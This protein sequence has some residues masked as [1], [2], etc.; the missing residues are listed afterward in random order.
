MTTS[1]N[2]PY[3]IA[4]ELERPQYDTD[5]Y[6]ADAH[7]TDGVIDYPDEDGE[8]M[9]EG[10]IQRDYIHYSTKA[11][12][13]YYRH[14]PDV[15]VSGNLFIYYEE[16]N[17]R[18]SLAPDT[19]V[20]IGIPN[21]D[22]NTYKVWLEGG[23][24]PDFA[25]EI[26]SHSTVQKDN[27][28]KV[29]LYQQLGVQEYIQYDPTAQYLQPVP[30]IGYQ[31]VNGVYKPMLPR[32]LA[33]GTLCLASHVLNLELHL[34]SYGLRFYDPEQQ[35]YLLTQE[36]TEYALEQAEQARLQAEQARL[37]AEQARLQ[38]EQIAQRLAERLRELGVDPDTVV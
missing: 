2:P 24:L 17:P 20:V 36:E 4:D 8:G 22:R 7:D 11:L 30:L 14:R 19:F 31:L 25:L 15:Y 21:H 9:P 3:A 1:I 10:D 6:N 38:A 18:A 35:R 26:T 27:R 32:T 28:N 37:Q 33:D 5:S 12:R 16:G 13:M 29:A 34:L 23:K